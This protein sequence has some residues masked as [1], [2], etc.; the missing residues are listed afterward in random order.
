MYDLLEIDAVHFRKSYI[1]TLIKTLNKRD[2]KLL[3]DPVIAEALANMSSECFVQGSAAL[4][5]DAEFI[6]R[7]WPFDVTKIERPV[8]IWQGTD[9]HFV[10]Y[11]INREVSER[12]PGAV[13]HAVE[14]EDHF[15]PIPESGN[16]FAIAARELGA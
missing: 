2:A 14:G 9:D 7:K 11:P 13:W 15:M 1:K 12:M 5:Q 8:H 4:V 6:Y 10:P 16:I 3:E